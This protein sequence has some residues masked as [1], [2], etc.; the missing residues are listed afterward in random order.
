MSDLNASYVSASKPKAG[1]AIYR[2]SS[3]TATI[4]TDITT[5]LTGYDSLG[6]I[7]DEGYTND[8]SPQSTNV[9][10]WGGDNV[11]TTQ[12]DKPDSF[13][14]KLIESL[15]VAVL[16]TVYGDANVTGD[17]KTG[18]TITANG[19]QLDERAFVID[20]I[21]RDNVASRTVIPR[22][23]ISSIASIPHKDGEPIAYEITI[24]AIPDG[25]GNTHY[26]Y[27]KKAE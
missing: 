15:N 7:S 14:F 12:T 1:G 6:Y 17:I 16:K 3:S 22:G 21:L 13:K 5:A 20:E 27:L 24:L 11:L 10:A 9:K 19:K 4:P 8:N 2:A 26:Q 23:Q 18:I 25:T